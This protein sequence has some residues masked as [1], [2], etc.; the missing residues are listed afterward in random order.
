MFRA[1]QPPTVVEDFFQKE[2]DLFFNTLSDRLVTKA[3]PFYL[4]QYGIINPASQTFL[5]I[6]VLNNGAHSV[7]ICC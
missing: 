1:A 4:F 7:D 5:F 3:L 2:K 6:S